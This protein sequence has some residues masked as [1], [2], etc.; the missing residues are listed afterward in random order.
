M[1]RRLW[2]KLAGHRW[3]QVVTGT[4][5]IYGQPQFFTYATRCRRCGAADPDAPE[6]G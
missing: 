3:G 1:I 4:W 5:A 2:C 6:V